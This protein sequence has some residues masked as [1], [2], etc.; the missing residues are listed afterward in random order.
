[1]ESS[2]SASQARH[3]VLQHDVYQS[4]ALKLAPKAIALLK[5]KFQ[6]VTVGTCLG[7]PEEKWYRE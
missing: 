2:S 6:L 5:D 4:T 1:M 7:V 3:I